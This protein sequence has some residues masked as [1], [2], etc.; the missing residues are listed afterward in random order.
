MLPF[1]GADRLEPVDR[2]R[3]FREQTE[4]QA[5]AASGIN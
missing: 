4:G 3:R 1:Q 5:K 2:L